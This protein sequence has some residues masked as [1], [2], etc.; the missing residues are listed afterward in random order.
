MTM[1]RSSRWL[2]GVVVAAGVIIATLLALLSGGSESASAQ[3]ARAGGY[4]PGAV[5][6]RWAREAGV[7]Q[8]RVLASAG[9]VDRDVA[10]VTGRNGA[11]VPCWTAVGSGGRVAGPFRCGAAVPTPGAALLVFA[12]VSG[13]A[14]STTADAVTLLGFIRPDVASVEALL[15]GGTTKPLA[16]TNGTFSYAAASPAELPTAMRAYNAAGRLVGEQ[17]I[18]LE[19]GPGS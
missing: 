18:N 17:A 8:L 6:A 4:V 7:S 2:L 3:P 15:V 9:G 10:I 19:S 11:G 14:G 5:V 12:R 16:T 13:P 1:N